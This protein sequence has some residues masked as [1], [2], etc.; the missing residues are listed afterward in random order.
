M[1]SSSTQ[2]SKM[3]SVIN[4]LFIALLSGWTNANTPSGCEQCESWPGMCPFVDYCVEHCS[5]ASNIKESCAELE[6][7]T[8]MKDSKPMSDEL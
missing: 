5:V 3:R 6:D 2:R 4:L 8:L 7:G 1:T